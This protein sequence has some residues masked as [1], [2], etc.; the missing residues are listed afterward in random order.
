MG[1]FQVQARSGFR[2]NLDA[3]PAWWCRFHHHTQRG[4][5][6]QTS[7]Q[8][9]S[10]LGCQV[11]HFEVLGK[12]TC[13]ALSEESPTKANQDLTA[14]VHAFY[15]EPARRQK[16]LSAVKGRLPVVDEAPAEKFPPG[17]LEADEPG[18]D[19]WRSLFDDDGPPQDDDQDALPAP[20]Q[21]TCAQFRLT[22][23]GRQFLQNC[24]VSH[25]NIAAVSTW[26]AGSSLSKGR[27]QGLDLAVSEF[28]TA[29]G[30]LNAGSVPLAAKLNEDR[31]SD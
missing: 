7:E 2:R 4:A 25:H 20:A 23:G 3:D 1:E 8:I 17:S 11:R 31:V 29:A 13:K 14:S 18:E 28:T 12:R 21:Q 9:S 16:S 19:N 26:L 10:S 27:K 5:T 15:R 30:K 24:S 6:L 22:P